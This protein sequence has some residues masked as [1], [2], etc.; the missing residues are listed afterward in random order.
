MD[1]G[2]HLA[3]ASR[4]GAR[5]LTKRASTRLGSWGRPRRLSGAKVGVTHPNL[6][7]SMRRNG[8]SATFR[9]PSPDGPGHKERRHLSSGVVSRYPPIVLDGVLTDNPRRSPMLPSPSACRPVLRLR[10]TLWQ[11]LHVTPPSATI[12]K[13]VADR[14]IQGAVVASGALTSTDAASLERI[15]SCCV[16]LQNLRRRFSSAR[17]WPASVASSAV[18]AGRRAR[19]LTHER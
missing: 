5:Y 8:L 10:A 13:G 3:G 15:R 2:H 4:G 6:S 16:P 18:D 7:V 1:G 9:R 12:P 11:G 17:G 14:R 19:T